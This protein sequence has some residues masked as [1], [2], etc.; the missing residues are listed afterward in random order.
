MTDTA[1]VKRLQEKALEMRK[2]LLK[3]CYISGMLHIGGD[4]SLADVMTGIWQYAIRYDAKNPK[5]DGRDRFILSKGHSAGVLYISQA[6][7]GCYPLEEVFNTY[8]CLDSA[9]GMHPCSN[10]LPSIEISTGALGHGLS[11]SVGL[12]LAARYLGKKHRIFTVIGDG[13]SQ[14]G[15][16]WEAAMAAGQFKLG[17]IVAFV[18]RNGLSL[19]DFT[20]TTMKLEPLEDKWRSFGWNAKTI[21]GH[22]MAQIVDALDSMPPT[23]STVPTVFIAKTV[24]GRG[25]S[26]MENKPE[27]HAGSVDADTLEKCYLEL[28][29][30]YSAER[31]K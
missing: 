26:F 15:S 27:W 9:F 16:I 13:E 7:Y 30:K 10:T 24:K 28:D 5:W 31:G 6:L 21:N 14:E 12:A 3:L 22:D 4:L 25:I 23:D 11:I 2:N 19:D 17:N 29:E 18:D 8:N 1:T 20:E